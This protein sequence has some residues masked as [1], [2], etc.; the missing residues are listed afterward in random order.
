MDHILKPVRLV[1]IRNSQR[2]V[3][4]RVNVRVSLW[5]PTKFGMPAGHPAAPRPV[6]LQVEDNGGHFGAT[7]EQMQARLAGAYAFVMWQAGKAGFQ[8][9]P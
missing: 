1:R 8:Q 7:T 5:K 6:L 2:V 4:P 3:Y 9:G